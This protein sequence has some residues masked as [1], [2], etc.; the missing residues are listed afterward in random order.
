MIAAV[1]SM[2]AVG[3]FAVESQNVVGYQNK[4]LQTSKF[5]WCCG[6]FQTVGV[7]QD[8][9]KL[10]DV[11]LANEDGVS[12]GDVTLSIIGG[13]GSNLKLT[14]AETTGFVGKSASF[15]YLPQTQIDEAK[16]D[17]DYEGELDGVV[18]GWYHETDDEFK[19]CFNDYALPFGAGY[20][21]KQS[22][23]GYTVV[24][25]G[26]V[27]VD[28]NMPS[29]TLETSKFVWTGN[30]SPK[31][32]TLGDFSVSNGDG[33]SVGDVTLSIIS[34][35]GSNLKL[36]SAETTGFVGKSASFV[37]LPQEQIDEVKADP[38][39]EGELDGVVAGWYHET[40][41]EFKECFNNYPITAGLAFAVKQTASGYSIDLP[42]AL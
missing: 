16:A 7:D 31:D 27:V 39:Y 38:D 21:V 10:G 30:A 9:M 3:A 29:I 34:G 36:T 1:A 22:A 20:A 5:V 17:P 35:T 32:M 23:P 14:S 6:T 18:A 12:V 4:T 11:T 26:E 41:D 33:V 13:A 25:A 8:K 40:D 37:Y 15:V 2:A 42:G 24:Y 19:E 28:A